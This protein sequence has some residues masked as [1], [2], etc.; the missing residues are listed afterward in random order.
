[1]PQIVPY[2]ASGTDAESVHPSSMIRRVAFNV[3]G[4][5]REAVE[6]AISLAL[7][8]VEE[9]GQSYRIFVQIEQIK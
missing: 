9:A 5:N 3:S 7:A 6:F 2:S 1:M 4:Y 8:R